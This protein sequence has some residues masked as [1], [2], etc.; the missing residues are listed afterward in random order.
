MESSKQLWH[1]EKCSLSVEG[2]GVANLNGGSEAT[3]E[4]LEERLEDILAWNMLTAVSLPQP[5]GVQLTT[6]DPRWIGCWWLGPLFSGAVLILIGTIILAYPRELPGAKAIRE[7]A[8]AK[9]E[10]IP[11]DDKIK[12]NLKDIIPASRKLVVNATFVSQTFAATFG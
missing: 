4:G 8:I 10:L 1:E 9:G 5:D 6:K 3:W 2:G 11:N 7:N 12:G